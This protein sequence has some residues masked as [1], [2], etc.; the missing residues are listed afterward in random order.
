MQASHLLQQLWGNKEPLEKGTNKASADTATELL[1]F[2][3]SLGNVTLPNIGTFLLWFI[4]F[5]MLLF[6]T[7]FK[8]SSISF[9]R[10]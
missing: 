9:L 10:L 8:S 4:T 2:S 7:K 5:K 3:E 6:I 1:L